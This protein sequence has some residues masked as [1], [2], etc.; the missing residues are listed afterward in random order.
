M[1]AAEVF[2]GQPRTSTGRSGR[3]P[4]ALRVQ[5]STCRPRRPT[6][7]SK[8]CSRFGIARWE[9]GFMA[10]AFREAPRAC[11]NRPTRARSA[12]RRSVQHDSRRSK[13]S[14]SP[15]RAVG[16][17]GEH[18]RRQLAGVRVLP[19]RVVGRDHGGPPAAGRSPV[20]E[21]R[22]GSD[23]RCRG[24]RA[25]ARSRRTRSGRARRSPRTRGSAATSATRCGWH[26][27]ISAGVGLLS[28]GAQRTAA[29]M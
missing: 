14:C 4:S 18:R 15:S 8:A 1:E 25:D 24:P 9:F 20:A 21:Q 10:S 3:R 12:A 29:A 6:P 22:S 2:F 17:A 7:D 23:A 19:A 26:A 27:A 13:R 16:N 5:R 11:L 28:G